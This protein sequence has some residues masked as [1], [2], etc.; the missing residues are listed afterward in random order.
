[1]D[2]FISQ[3]K[4]D[5]A[6]K[7][8]GKTDKKAPDFF[9]DAICLAPTGNAEEDEE[10]QRKMLAHPIW[11]TVDDPKKKTKPTDGKKGSFFAS[12]VKFVGKDGVVKNT[13]FFLVDGTEVYLDKTKNF[14]E[15]NGQYFDLNTLKDIRGNLTLIVDGAFIGTKKVVTLRAETVVLVSWSG[16]GGVVNKAPAGLNS[17]LNSV[18]EEERQ[19]LADYLSSMRAQKTDS[20]SHSPPPLDTDSKPAEPSTDASIEEILNRFGGGGSGSTD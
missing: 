6:D 14:K 20:E 7:K 18:S 4:A 12:H 13:R 10:N 15:K 19:A 5:K 16:M 9:G 17:M 3:Y 2:Q 11:D 1:M 8:A